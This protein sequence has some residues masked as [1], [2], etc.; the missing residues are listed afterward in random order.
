MGEILPRHYI[1][2]IIM[3]T[4]FVVGGMSILGILNEAKPS[5][6]VTDGYDQFNRSFNKLDDITIQVDTLESNIEN[7]D[8][9]VGLFGVLNGLIQTA[10]NS[11]SLIFTSF[12]FMDGAL[13]AL[14]TVFGVPTWIPLIIT[15]LIT[16]VLVF[17]ILSAIFQR[18]I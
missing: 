4:F 16:V 11:L 12:S 3:F 6:N 10:W 1:F 7:A 15:L 13:E 8:P 2:G 5:L 18:E 14:S 9:D 17:A